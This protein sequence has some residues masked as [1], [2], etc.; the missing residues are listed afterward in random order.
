VHVWGLWRGPGFEHQVVT[1][2][3]VLCSLGP[4]SRPDHLV[5]GINVNRVRS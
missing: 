1:S 2:K 4:V 3:L 5:E